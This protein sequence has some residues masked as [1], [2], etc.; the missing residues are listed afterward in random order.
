MQGPQIVTVPKFETLSRYWIVPFLHAYLSYYGAIGSAFN[1]TPGQSL[2]VGRS[3]AQAYM[4]H[5]M[6]FAASVMSYDTP[7]IYPFCGMYVKSRSYLPVHSFSKC[8][9]FTLHSLSQLHACLYGAECLFLLS[10]HLCHCVHFHSSK[11]CMHD[12]CRSMCTLRQALEYQFW[13][14]R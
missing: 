5:S 4:V 14:C 6:Q 1:S 13:C 2:V 12:S 10:S 9:H 8:A 11:H 7:P 3:K